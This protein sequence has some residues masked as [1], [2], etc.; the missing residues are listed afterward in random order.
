[1]LVTNKQRDYTCSVLFLI[2]G[3]FMYTQSLAIEPL[4]GKDVGSGFVPKIVAIGITAVSA[5][6]LMLTACAKKEEN[7][8]REREDVGGGLLTIALLAV[9]VVIFKPLGFLASTVIY[10]F[11]QMTL[12]STE[13]NRNF[14]LFGVISAAAPV[15][16]YTIFEYVIKMPLPAGILSF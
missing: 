5:V 1:M 15:L 4:M 2:F 12:L 14:I 10:L 16:I 11:F 8:V 9:Y 3:I 7:Y 6:K 13:Q